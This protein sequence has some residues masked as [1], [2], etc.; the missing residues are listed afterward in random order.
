MDCQY[1]TP[2]SFQLQ[3]KHGPFVEILCELQMN[4]DVLLANIL[5][6]RMLCCNPTNKPFCTVEHFAVGEVKVI[7]Y[8]SHNFPLIKLL[9]G[10]CC[11]VYTG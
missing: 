9:H 5:S 4:E 7:A 2:L 6:M 11:F 3:K 1:Q 10:P 8:N